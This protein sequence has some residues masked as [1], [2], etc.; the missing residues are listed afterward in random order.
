MTRLPVFFLLLSMLISCNTDNDTGPDRHEGRRINMTGVS[1]LAIATDLTS[2][3]VRLTDDSSGGILMRITQEGEVTKMGYVDEF[4]NPLE[5]NEYLMQITGYENYDEIFVDEIYDLHPDYYLLVGASINCRKIYGD[6]RIVCN[7]YRGSIP[8]WGKW[9]NIQCNIHELYNGFSY[10]TSALVIVHKSTGKLYNFDQTD[11]CGAFITNPDFRDP[12]KITL[13]GAFP[14]SNLQYDNENRIYYHGSSDNN[15]WPYMYGLHRL[16]LSNPEELN[17]EELFIGN[18]AID[19]SHNFAVDGNGNVLYNYDRIRRA[20]GSVAVLAGLNWPYIAWQSPQR[21]MFAYLPSLNVGGQTTSAVVK[22]EQIGSEF[23]YS[24]QWT[25]TGPHHLCGGNRL[26]SLE[27]WSYVGG[28]CSW[29]YN[30][31]T[32]KLET[33]QLPI[34]GRLE[35]VSG[36]Y[37]YYIDGTK[38][39]RL[40]ISDFSYSSTTIPS[41][42]VDELYHVNLN[43]STEEILF[44]G[45]RY[46]D[47]KVVEY[48]MTFQGVVTLLGESETTIRITKIVPVG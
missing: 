36:E 21:E 17:N 8:L 20:D 45:F 15:N 4:G 10:L 30:Y 40:N 13:Y 19:I 33:F 41:G 29:R 39:D 34:S 18:Q 2:S 44:G 22:I 5:K 7:D 26:A 14:I 37:I 6:Q 47:G 24:V 46:S 12:S 31:A 3:N 9:N 1:A 28:S 38:I 42:Y 32:R 43:A 23:T 27:N 16:N 48:S 25:G 35:G 11:G